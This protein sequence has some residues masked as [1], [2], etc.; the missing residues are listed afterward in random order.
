MMAVVKEVVIPRSGHWLMEEQPTA[1]I[2]A[3]AAFLQ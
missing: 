1:A 2:T 3:I